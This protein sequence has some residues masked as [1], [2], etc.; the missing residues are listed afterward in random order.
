MLETAGAH[1][2]LFLASANR[3]LSDECALAIPTWARIMFEKTL[4]MPGRQ[5]FEDKTLRLRGFGF[6]TLFDRNSSHLL[7]DPACQV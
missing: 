3:L 6:W 4:P 2:C 5:V 7:G 1:I